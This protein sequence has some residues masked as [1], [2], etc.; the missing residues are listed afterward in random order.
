MRR[1]PA[2]RWAALAAGAL[3]LGLLW[4]PY[5]AYQDQRS[6]AASRAACE[7]HG[8]P[9]WQQ[10]LQEFSA[11]HH[12]GLPSPTQ[13]KTLAYRHRRE[14][15]I[16]VLECNTGADYQWNDAVRTVGGK[17]VPLAWCGRPHGFWR[18]WRNVLYSDLTLRQVPEEEVRRW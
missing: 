2:A 17:P 12:G 9:D 1:S 15:D 11:G 5:A 16:P 18:K 13:R 7:G 8:L 3:C 6:H 4:F 10:L 14:S